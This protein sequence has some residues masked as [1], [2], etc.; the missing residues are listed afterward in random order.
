MWHGYE[1]K[2]VLTATVSVDG[3][4]GTHVQQCYYGD[5]GWD[6]FEEEADECPCYAF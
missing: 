6:K 2:K 5:S 3:S 4:D 1:T